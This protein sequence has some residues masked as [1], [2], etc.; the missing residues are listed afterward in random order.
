M[1]F[2]KELIELFSL[3]KVNYDTANRKT[4]DSLVKKVKLQERRQALFEL[5]CEAGKK[6]AEFNCVNRKVDQDLHRSCLR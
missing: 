6:K 3:K 1:D 4:L 2:L 5:S